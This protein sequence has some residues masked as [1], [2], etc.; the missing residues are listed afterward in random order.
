MPIRNSSVPVDGLAL[1]YPSLLM[2]EDL[3][4]AAGPILIELSTDTIGDVERCHSF[5]RESL[6]SGRAMY[7]STTGFGAL[8]GHSG[9]PDP[10]DQTHG[11][12]DFLAA[13]Q[14]PSLAPQVVRA[15]LL[16]RAWTLAR[17]QSGVS[18][19]ALQVLLEVLASPLALAPVVP[20]YG[21]VGA[22]GD[23][24][25]MSHAL[26]ALMG[27]GDM[28]IDGV[29]VPAADALRTAGLDQLVLEGRDGLALVN[30]T[31]L[32]AAAAGLACAQAARSV[33]AAIT[34][35]GL[36]TEVLG[37]GPEYAS[38]SLAVASGH[39]GCVAVSGLL[40]D[41]LDGCVPSGKRQ[42][43]EPYSVRCVP[44]LVGAAWTSVRHA[45]TVTIADLNGVSDNPVFFPEEGEIVHGGNF[46]G[47]PVAFAADL[48]ASAL[49]QLANLAERQLDLLMDPH[50]NTGL[51]PSLS[52]DPGRQHGLTGVQLSTT[53]IVVAMRRA[54]V[55]AAFQSLSTN[56]LNQDVVPFGTQAALTALA[57]AERLRW[58]HGALAVALRQ[59]VHLGG[60]TP[61]SEQ[62][63]AL[64]ERL[65][66][67]VAPIP[68]DRPLDGDVRRAADLL[69]EVAVAHV[70]SLRESSN[71]SRS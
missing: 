44:Q 1:K 58:V 33:V 54:A 57:Q 27:R 66:E 2:P 61:A 4:A 10:A 3:E 7:G 68:Y 42:L 28:L 45:T 52:A 59:A 64:L 49:T 70:P 13:G 38:D 19:G 63:A 67:T 71:T 11:L 16:A 43:Q 32:T 69:D 22:S 6:E 34:L 23:L 8:V 36:M 15:M 29:R 50:R 56:Q 51:N 21:S 37:A 60:R 20:E 48:L 5:V 65:C 31:P 17:G 55:P 25:P 14:G 35:T 46:F 30:G 62:G 9:R 39:A 40:R 41:V 47:Q 53:S 26:S 18:G 12:V 24:V